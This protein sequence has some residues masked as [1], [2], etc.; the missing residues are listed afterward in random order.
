MATFSEL[1][2]RVVAKY[3]GST[4]TTF[5]TQAGD[6]INDAIEYYQREH[7][8]F[9]EGVASVTLTVGSNEVSTASGFPTDYWYINPN[10]GMALVQSNQRF[11]LEKISIGEYDENNN[12][13]TGRPTVFREIG[14]TM[15]VYPYPDQAYVVEFRYIKKYTALTGS[16][17]NDFT[18]YAPQLLEARALSMLFL[19]QGQDETGMRNFWQEEERN[20]LMSL[21]R[22]SNARMA[23]GNLETD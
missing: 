14:Q 9:S 16:Q 20:Q 23:T 18:V 8:W 5:T 17:S 19:A 1:A 6:A 13:G 22:T 11:V 21:K 2:S 10:G 3:K 12:Q 7:F 15:Q 4:G